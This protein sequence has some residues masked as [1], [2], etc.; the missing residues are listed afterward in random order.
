MKWS[1]KPSHATVPLSVN[2][3]HKYRML[4]AIDW[5]LLFTYLG[6]WSSRVS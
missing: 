4:L 1:K 2:A 5:S 3:N 6:T